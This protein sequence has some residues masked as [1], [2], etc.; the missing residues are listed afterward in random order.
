M[1]DT[2]HVR[3]TRFDFVVMVMN[4]HNIYI[5]GDTHAYQA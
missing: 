2:L 4:D 1:P 3:I 5:A